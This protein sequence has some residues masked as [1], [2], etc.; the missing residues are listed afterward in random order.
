MATIFPTAMPLTGLLGINVGAIPGS[1]SPWGF[2]AGCPML[3]AIAIG[4][5]FFFKKKQVL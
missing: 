4:E 2:V 1:D 5:Y 3:V